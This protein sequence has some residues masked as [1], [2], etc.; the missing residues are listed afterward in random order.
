MTHEEHIADPEYVLTRVTDYLTSVVAHLQQE[1]QTARDYGCSWT[2]A[3]LERRIYDAT[4]AAVIIM[5]RR[6]DMALERQRKA[7]A[8]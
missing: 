4:D 8:K 5:A 2:A 6:V 3:Q 1:Q 7:E